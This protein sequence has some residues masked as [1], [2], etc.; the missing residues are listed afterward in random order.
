MI[1]FIPSE[2]NLYIEELYS[3]DFINSEITVYTTKGKEM[4]LSFDLVGDKMFKNDLNIFII[5]LDCM[6]NISK[7]RVS[8]RF[9]RGYRW[10]DDI[11]NN[12]KS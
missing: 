4:N 9:E 5:D 7:F 10:L 2:L 8:L 11:I 6:K 1:G 12:S 3:K